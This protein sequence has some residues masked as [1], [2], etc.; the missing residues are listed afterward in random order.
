LRLNDLV[1]DADQDFPL[2]ERLLSAGARP[3]KFHC[4]DRIA[5][6]AAEKAELR[7]TTGA[8]AVEMESAVIRELCRARGIPSATLRVISDAADEDLPL[9]FNKVMTPEMRLSGSQLAKSL[10]CSPG[11]SP[12]LLSFQKQVRSAA[13]CLGRALEVAMEL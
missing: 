5:A 4:A 13:K 11:L 12:K 10:L 2:R 7:R 1:F 8:D 3:A 9:D 6:T